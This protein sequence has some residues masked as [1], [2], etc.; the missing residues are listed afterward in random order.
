MGRQRRAISAS[1]ARLFVCPVAR[2]E[3]GKQLKCI[4]DKCS[5]WEWDAI[6]IYPGGKKIPEGFCTY[7]IVIRL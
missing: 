6:R 4:V 3:H 7:G 2:K 5:L 1:V